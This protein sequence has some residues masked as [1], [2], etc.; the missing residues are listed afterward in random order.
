MAV[1]TDP[2]FEN[3]PNHTEV[4]FVNADGTTA[5]TIFTAGAD[6]SVIT[7]I[8]VTSDDTSAV[9]L[10]VYLNDGATDYL[11]GAINVPTLSGTDGSA[12]AVE[13]CDP[14]FIPFFAGGQA[15]LKTGYSI[16]AGPQAAVTAAKT[17]TIVGT[18]ADYTA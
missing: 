16:K 14:A 2:V 10:N 11:L 1:N 12:P 6:G 8:N 3:A 9:V 7:G 18:G 13:G 5:K 15:R 4:T 17:V